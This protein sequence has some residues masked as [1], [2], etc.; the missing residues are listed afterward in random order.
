MSRK[1]K[2]GAR[3]VREKRQIP[4]LEGT[5]Q[6]TREGYAFIIVDGE[7]DDVYIV[8]SEFLDFLDGSG[9]ITFVQA[10]QFPKCSFLCGAQKQSRR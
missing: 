4:V 1:R 2:F 7:E 8:P 9:Y 10:V 5:V 6:M 3:K